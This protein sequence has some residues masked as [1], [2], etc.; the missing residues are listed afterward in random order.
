MAQY[1]PSSGDYCRP[2]TSP[3][4]AFPIKS[5]QPVS[6]IVASSVIPLG[7]QVSL[8]GGTSTSA[9]Q[10]IPG[11]AL[12]AAATQNVGI[13][14]ANGANAA[15]SS[16]TA[17]GFIPVWEANP[18]VEFKAVSKGAPLGSSHVG[19]RR[20]L[21]WDSTLNVQYVDLTASTAADWRVV[22]TGILPQLTGNVEGDSGGYVS[23]RFLPH[24]TENIGSSVA[25]TSTTPILAFYS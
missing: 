11:A 5:M 25:L 22:V 19:L 2:L 1:T 20:S 17:N 21:Q 24:L 14:A 7:R 6:S 12:G 16:A 18:M 4:G 23:F 15:N 10:I 9:G 8:V 13:A 3:W